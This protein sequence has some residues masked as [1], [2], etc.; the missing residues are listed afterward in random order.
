M[1]KYINTRKCIPNQFVFFLALD[2]MLLALCLPA[3]AQQTTKIP[4]V[5]FLVASTPSN[6]VTRIETF[7][8]AMR[9]LGYVE[10]K[11][12]NIEYRYG[13]G[14]EERFREIAAEFV[15]LKVDVFITAAN[16]RAAKNATK[17]IP[18]VFAAIADPVASGIV[19][20]LARPGEN[21]T[22]VTVLAPEL[23]GKRIELLKETVPKITRLAFLW[24]PSAPGDH[25]LLKEAEVASPALGLQLRPLEV[26]SV[27]D[28]ENAFA[29]A[30][31]GAQG[32]T[33]TLN[34][35]LNTHRARIIDFVAKNRLP[36]VFG[37]PEIVEAG[38][39][40]AYG[41][42]YIEHFRRL[43]IFVDKVLKGAKP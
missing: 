1:T 28:L 22:G 20:S 25:V 12:I 11:N 32:L 26:S 4:R 39:L 9:E 27:N 3:E 2:A 17:T 31:E 21:I 36:A 14:K 8:Q 34:P 18:I 6:Y 7:R 10:G 16:A 15:S 29:T 41:P 13:E 5:G 35:F 30:K 19:D 43:A 24:N 40:M 33:M 37:A 23:T 42:D 38:G